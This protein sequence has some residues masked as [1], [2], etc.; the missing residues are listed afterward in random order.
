M[1]SPMPQHFRPGRWSGF[2]LV[3]SMAMLLSA[4]TLPTIA[5][6]ARGDDPLLLSHLPSPIQEL[7]ERGET[8]LDDLTALEQELLALGLV[9]VRRLDPTLVVDL[10]YARD[11]NFMG[12]N[13]YGDL[14]RALLVPVAAEK[15][16]KAH[17]S[18]K[19]RNPDYRLL[20]FDAFRPRR[21]QFLMWERVQGTPQ[22]PYVANPA[23]GSMHNYGA[24]VDI[25]IVNAQGEQLDMGTPVDHFGMLAQ[26]REEERFLREG[27]LTAGQLANRRLLREVMEEAGFIQLP[28]EWW[29][30]DA[31]DRRE[32]RQTYR[33]ID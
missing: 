32:V 16:A 30:F 15:L 33:I 24:A 13:V 22:Q 1:D 29:H 18:L 28:I 31:L 21:V 3:W 20:V 12:A 25:T 17:E 11:E 9:D 14:R 27:K 10:K 6:S 8:Y 2:C 7:Q 19:Q 26:P 5:N 23:T 4:S